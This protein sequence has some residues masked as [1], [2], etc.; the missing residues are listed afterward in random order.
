MC[1]LVYRLVVTT[2]L[3]LALAGRVTAQTFTTLHNFTALSGSLHTNSDGANPYA[4]LILSGNTLYGT[5]ELGGSGGRGV[6]FSLN[7]DGKGFRT[8]HSFD[9]AGGGSPVTGLILSGNTL[10]GTTESGGV[11]GKGTVF[12]LNTDGTGFAN[13][14]AFR[15]SD[16]N[17]RAPYGTPAFFGNS[18]AA[19]PW[20]EVILSGKRLYGTTQAGGRSGFGTVFAVNTDGTG[21]RLVHTFT[22]GSDGSWPYGRLVLSG[23]TL[24]GTASG[25]GDSRWGT[26]FAV[27][28]DGTGFATLHSFTAIPGP[29][30]GNYGGTNADGVQPYAGLIL[31]GHTLYGTTYY[32]GSSGFG[33]VFGVNTDGT[34]F[35][36]LHSFTALPP[37]P[38]GAALPPTN[39]DGANPYG[40]LS[41]S[42]HTLYGTTYYGGSSGHGTVFSISL[43]APVKPVIASPQVPLH[44]LTGMA[45]LRSLVTWSGIRDRTRT[46]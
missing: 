23:N 36:N 7:T 32:G 11:A 35:T 39:S 29:Y 3:S 8:L 27:N 44:R 33:T 6:V 17:G 13:L 16:L 38:G 15:L 14:H 18:D 42:G 37:F 9:L 1:N 45:R 28:T 4:G 5:T 46:D 31:A 24:Y 21:F 30:S 19:G 40:G 20:S 43:L 41:L 10:Y 12:G 22:N 2:G 25:G 34:G 26:V